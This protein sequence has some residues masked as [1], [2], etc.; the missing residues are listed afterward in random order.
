MKS[1]VWELGSGWWLA[2]ADDAGTWERSGFWEADLWGLGYGST[3]ICLM[4]WEKAPWSNPGFGAESMRDWV[5]DAM[6]WIAER[7]CVVMGL[8]KCHSLVELCMAEGW[9]KEADGDVEW[10]LFDWFGLEVETNP[11][12]DDR[13]KRRK[14]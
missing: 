12:G 13:P 1:K 4:T 2:K 5:E 6:N 14:D 11:D 8:E 9:E 7:P 10:W 3:E